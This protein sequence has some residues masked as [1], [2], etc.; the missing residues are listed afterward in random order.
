MPV[1]ERHT[2]VERIRSTGLDRAVMTSLPLE[3]EPVIS[4]TQLVP[5]KEIGQSAPYLGFV[6]CNDYLVHRW[7]LS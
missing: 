5:W 2:D 3:N 1:H 7:A 6:V 4:K